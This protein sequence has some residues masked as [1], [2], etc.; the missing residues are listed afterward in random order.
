M[1][2]L[3]IKKT[4]L[5]VQARATFALMGLLLLARTAIGENSN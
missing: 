2:D 1:T 5:G 3:L 4:R